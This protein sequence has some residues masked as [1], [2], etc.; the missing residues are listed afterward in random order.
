MS[1]TSPAPLRFIFEGSPFQLRGLLRIHYVF[2][3][4]VPPIPLQGHGRFAPRTTPD[5]TIHCR[6]L[7]IPILPCPPRK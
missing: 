6:S 7:A 5:R 2:I 4:G 3:S 1:D